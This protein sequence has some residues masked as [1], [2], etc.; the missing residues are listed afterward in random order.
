LT[1][2]LFVPSIATAEA[3]GTVVPDWRKPYKHSGPWST[4]YFRLN[5]AHQIGQTAEA[6]RELGFLLIGDHVEVSIGTTPGEAPAVATLVRKLGGGT[7]PPL[8]DRYM[9]G[10]IPVGALATLASNPAVLTMGRISRPI[11]RDYLV[12][13]QAT[14]VAATRTAWQR[15]EPCPGGDAARLN[16]DLRD[17]LRA[18][19]SGTK[20][21]ERVVAHLFLT[22]PE[23]DLAQRYDLRVE[24]RSDDLIQV[25]VALSRL[26]DLVADGR[27]RAVHPPMFAPLRR[28]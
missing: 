27:V 9:N 4:D 2:A 21:D 8:Q 17:R 5:Q 6:A 16:P 18:F 28:T 20:G 26:C 24:G 12:T 14:S 25:S 15:I 13:A 23:G 3:L 7:T 1:P 10:Y 22:Q 19:V 11:I